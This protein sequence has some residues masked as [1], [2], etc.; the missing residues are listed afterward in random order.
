MYHFSMPN[1]VATLFNRAMIDGNTARFGHCHH[2]SD[3]SENDIFVGTVFDKRN[4]LMTYVDI[5]FRID[6]NHICII[7]W[8]GRNERYETFVSIGHEDEVNEDVY[9]SFQAALDH[10]AI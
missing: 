1:A 10:A 8:F 6:E 4:Q 9:R 3:R 5:G 7:F 2:N